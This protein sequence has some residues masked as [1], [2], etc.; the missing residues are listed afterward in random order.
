MVI[1]T[2][3]NHHSSSQL[4]SHWT[5]LLF[6]HGLPSCKEIS[7]HS[8]VY[9]SWTFSISLLQE[10]LTAQSCLSSTLSP[11]ITKH[12]WHALVSVLVGTFCLEQVYKLPNSM[13]VCARPCIWIFYEWTC[14]DFELRSLRISWVVF[15]LQFWCKHPHSSFHINKSEYQSNIDFQRGLILVLWLYKF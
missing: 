7:V 10:K 15:E 11:F 2:R 13:I 8:K 6:D 12:S 4:W 14:F 9:W 5:A 1:S 3:L